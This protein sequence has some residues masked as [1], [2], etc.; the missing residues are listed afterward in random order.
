[1][2]LGALAVASVSTLLGA[3]ACG[4]LDPTG[5]DSSESSVATEQDLVLAPVLDATTIPRFATQMPRLLTYVPTLIRNGAGQVIRKEFTVRIA[6]FNQQQLPSGF[7]STQLFGYGGN[8]R[9]NGQTVFQRTSPGPTFEQTRNIPA[10]VRYRNELAGEHPLAVDPTL[11]WANPNNFPKPTPPFLPFPPGYAQ[12]QSPIPHTTHTHGIE[13]LP[14][15]DG[16]PDTWYTQSGITGPE[17]VSTD[18]PQP[19]SNESTAFWYH[20]HTFGATRL[21]VGFGLSGYSILRD[22]QNPLDFVGNV[23]ILGFEDPYDWVT[24]VGTI[25]TGIDTRHTQGSFSTSLAARGFTQLQGRSFALTSTLPAS[26]SLDFFLPSQQPNPSFFGSVQLYANCPSKGVSRAFLSQVELT[27]RPTNQF[28]TLT[29]TIPAAVRTSVGSSCEDFAFET[30]IN[31]PSNATGTYLLDNLRGVPITPT[32]ALPEDQ[33]EVPMIIQDRTYR[34]D[35]SVFYPTVGRNPDVNPYW[36][37]TVDGS[38]NLVNGKVWP[39]FNVKRHL[40]RIRILNS[41]TQRFYNFRFS[42]G[43]SFRVIGTDGGYIPQARSINEALVGVTERV[44]LLVDFSQVAPGTRI[45]LQNTAQHFPPIGN[46]VDPNT[47]GTVMQFTVDAGPSVPPKAIPATLNVIQNLVPDRPERL[48]IQNVES[49]DQGRILQAELDGQ[50]FH[51][52]TTELPTVGATEDWNFINTTPLDHN[53]HVHLIQFLVVER[54]TFDNARYLADWIATNGNPPFSHPTIKLP[55]GP[56]LTSGAI[57][58]RPEESGWKDTVRTPAGQITRIRMR[59]APQKPTSPATPGVNTFPI[60]PVNG[61]GFIWHCHLVEH[62]DN[63]MMRPMT[64]IPIWMPNTVYPVG[65]RNS[66]GRGQGLVDFNGVDYAARV[67]H[68]SSTQTPIQRPDLWERIN[69][70][71]GDWAIQTIYQVGDRVRFTDGHIYRALQVHQAV[72]GN[73]PPAAAF[74]MLVL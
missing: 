61:I 33:F 59:F 56:Y 64:V 6:K 44:D 67:A 31:V 50:L 18:Y 63:E 22:P 71:N 23:D 36:E 42:N 58:P 54:H 70:Q 27:G 3:V 66:P 4:G 69:N 47:D 29:F 15:F 49:D 13:V 11:D 53:K 26:V 51:Q 12:A 7:P 65:N 60:N 73:A 48:L 17:F 21:N 5:N 43:M 1:L 14:E 55:I 68:T 38:T 74:W 40:Y 20:D 2:A 45:V 8:V 28:N 52:L 62:E 34:T 24:V 9:Q 41:S 10:L 32:T 35:G 19:S 25:P 46:P 72:A 16:T 30:A 37:L 57:A 39:N